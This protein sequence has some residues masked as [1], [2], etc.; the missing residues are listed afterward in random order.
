MDR[1]TLNKYDVQERRRHSDNGPLVKLIVQRIVDR[2]LIHIEEYSLHD[3]S[4]ER[5]QA[6]LEII[7]Q[8]IEEA[9]RGK[10]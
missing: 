8:K 1:E 5:R 10:D 4:P 7:M 6:A 3:D 9:E 2:K